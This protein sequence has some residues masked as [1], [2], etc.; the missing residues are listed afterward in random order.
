MRRFISLSFWTALLH[1]EGYASA[2]SPKFR[3][4]ASAVTREEQPS[5]ASDEEG[6]GK[7]ERK[8]PL[9]SRDRISKYAKEKQMFFVIDSAKDQVPILYEDPS[10]ALMNLTYVLWLC[11]PSHAPDINGDGQFDSLVAHVVSFT[12]HLDAYT[13]KGASTAGKFQSHGY[14]ASWSEESSYYDEY[15]VDFDD[16]TVFHIKGSSFNGYETSQA[17]GKGGVVIAGAGEWIFDVNHTLLHVM[18]QDM[19]LNVTDLSPDICA[20]QY[21]ETWNKNNAPGPE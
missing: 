3:L 1:V 19:D 16:T 6:C 8:A 2:A 9:T 14:T 17:G 15:I 4:K 10:K 18:A 5:D 11:A 20:K 7:T 21:A 12:P 13:E